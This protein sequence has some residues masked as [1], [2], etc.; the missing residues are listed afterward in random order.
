[1]AVLLFVFVVCSCLLLS[2]VVV[3]VVRCLFV[4][5]NT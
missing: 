3:V 1:M 4:V 5:V 2:F